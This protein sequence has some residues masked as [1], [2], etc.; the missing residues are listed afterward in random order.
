MKDTADIARFRENWQGEVDSAPEY[1]ALAAVEREHKIATVYLN[2]AKMEE[3][4]IFFW[5]ERLRRAGASPG[6]REPSWRSRVLRWIARRFGP[7][8][9]IST[10][11]AKETANRNV[12]AH[13]AETRWTRMHPKNAGTPWFWAN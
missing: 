4:H 8:T 1:S 7:E 9:V 2:L 10:I 11:A 3:A 12:Y 6:R 5:E 13:Q